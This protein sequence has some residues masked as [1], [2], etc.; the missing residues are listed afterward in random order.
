MMSCIFNNFSFALKCVMKDIMRSSATFTIN[1]TPSKSLISRGKNTISLNQ[2]FWHRVTIFCNFSFSL[3]FFKLYF[4]AIVIIYNNF[5]IES[6]SV[7]KIA[8]RIFKGNFTLPF[9]RVVICQDK[10][11]VYYWDVFFSEKKWHVFP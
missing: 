10:L 11:L 1:K 4:S 5:T 7:T 3:I 8:A 2:N 9:V 6:F